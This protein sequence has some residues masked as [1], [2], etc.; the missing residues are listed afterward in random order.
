MEKD[1]K[2]VVT[3]I[4][5]LTIEEIDSQ[6]SFKNLSQEKKL[7]L[8]LFLFQLSLVLYHSHSQNNDE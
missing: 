4:P 1:Q 2:N 8:I 6:E 3:E 7:E 5:K